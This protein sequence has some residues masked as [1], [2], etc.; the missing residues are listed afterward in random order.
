MQLKKSKQNVIHNIKS[1][2][3]VM[4]V[5]QDFVDL[6]YRPTFYPRWVESRRAKSLPVQGKR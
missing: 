2:F 6:Q 5:K 1:E 3:V 4:K